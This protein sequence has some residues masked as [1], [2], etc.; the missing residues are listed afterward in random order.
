[1]TKT[2]LGFGEVAKL[3]IGAGTAFTNIANGTGTTAFA[4]TST[5]LNNEYKRGTATTTNVTTTVAGD[6]AQFLYTFSITETKAI[7]EAGVFDANAAGTMI[8][9]QTFA[10]VNVVSGD[11]LA[12]TYKIQVT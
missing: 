6:T 4:A 9:A 1:M 3:I 2:N 7:T 11:S 10:A 12:I 5:Q 8:A